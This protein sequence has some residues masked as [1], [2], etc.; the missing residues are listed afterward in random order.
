MHLEIW[1]NILWSR[2]KAAVFSALGQKSSKQGH[3]LIVY[4]IAETEF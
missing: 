4:Q 1:H 2:Y 3:E